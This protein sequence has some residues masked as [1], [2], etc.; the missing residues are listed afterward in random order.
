MRIL[1]CLVFYPR[2]GSAQVVRYLSRAL[3]DQGHDVHLATGSL[4]DGDSQH[5]AGTFY[6]EIPLTIADYTEAWQGY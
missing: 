1:L 5:E 6:G 3:I 2:G 4:S